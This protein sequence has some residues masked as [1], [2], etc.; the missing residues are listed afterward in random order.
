MN[1]EVKKMWID[2]LESGEYK[3]GQGQLRTA[4]SNKFCCLG[5]LSDLAYKAGVIDEPELIDGDSFSG[6]RYDETACGLPPVVG[7]WAGLYRAGKF[8]VMND[9]GKSFKTIAN[10]I[11][12]NL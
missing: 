2:A 9:T 1:P 10:Y 12:E 5:V 4:A 7:E 8:I 3:Q 11:K 6:W